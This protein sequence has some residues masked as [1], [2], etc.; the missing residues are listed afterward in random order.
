[1]MEHLIFKVSNSI[2]GNGNT[3]QSSVYNPITGTCDIT[4]N[5][6]QSY[7]E[8]ATDLSIARTVIHESLHAIFVYMFEE[9]LLTSED[10]TPLEG[11]EDLLEAHINYL[12]DLPTNLGV[13][14]HTLMSEFIDEMAT[15][16][17]AYA[18]DNGYSN[19]FNFYKTLCWSGAIINTPT[20]QS[21]F[22]QYIDPNDALNNPG[23]VNPE[24]LN[25]INTNAA[26]QDNSTYSYAHPNGTTY[27]FNP[28]GSPPNSSEPCN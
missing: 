27:T 19:S 11:F 23:N 9:D 18:Q 4:I 13:A 10:G 22:P 1:M 25:I 15:S 7:L 5:I 8:T 20:F 16:L 14:H 17:S 6:R 12:N 21:L 26:E 2:T 28:V 24:W 3:S